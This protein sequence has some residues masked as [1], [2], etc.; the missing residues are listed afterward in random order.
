[1]NEIDHL[2]SF[3]SDYE[4]L[5][6]NADYKQVAERYTEQGAILTTYGET[7]NLTLDELRAFYARI[8]S[9]ACDFHFDDLQIEILS[10]NTAMVNAIMRFQLKNQEEVAKLMYTAVL[11]KSN[12]GWK[13]RHEHES[14]VFETFKNMLK[15]MEQTNQN[16]Q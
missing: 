10:D 8:P 13:I 14:P 7:K 6:A 12:Q 2:K 9:P 3:Y 4:Q 5:I 11:L 15:R 1:M 16:D